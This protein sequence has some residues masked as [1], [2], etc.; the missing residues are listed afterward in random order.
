M[1]ELFRRLD[2]FLHRRR[3]ERDLE[4]E[5][6][7][8]LALKSEALGVAD[9]RREFGNVTLLQEDCRTMWIGNF[10][11]QLAQDARYA[12]RMI[13][14]NR[15]FAAM[16][17]ISLA[18]GIGANTAIYSFVEAILLRSVPLVSHPEQLVVLNWHAQGRV[19]VA[20]SVAGTMYRENKAG[21]TSPN[22]PFG[23]Y[24]ALRTNPGPLSAVFGYTPAYGS[25][26]LVIHGQ[27]DTVPADY[28]SGNYY[29][30]LGVA[31]AAGRFIS[32]DDDR[33][34]APPVAVI[35]YKCWERRFGLDPSA[36]GR[37]IVINNIS[38][39][40]LGVT[41][42]GFFGVN[43]AAEPGVSLPLHTAP[44]FAQKPDVDERRR[45]LDRNFYWL[46]IFGRL[47]P[48]VTFEQAQS[49][50][51][52][53]FRQFA[54]STASS[55]A[56]R[57]NLP[58]LWL[59]EGRAGRDEL[60]RQYSTAIFVLMA[61]VGL[62]LAIACANI[63]N[64]LLA[65][66]ASRRREIAVRVSL[67]A[68]RWSVVR[69]LLT[70]SVLLSLLGG[71]LGLLV[72]FGG[73][74]FISWLLDTGR[75][76][77]T[78]HAGIN[79]PVLGFTLAL[80]LGTGVLFG[81]A[82]AW[83]ATRG[84]LTPALK[85]ARGSAPNRH[86]AAPFSLGQA[87]VVGQV[88][89]SLMLV[90]AAGLFVHTLVNLNSVHLGFQRENILL[91]KLNA[92][93][94]GYKDEALARFYAALD[95]SFQAIPGVRSAAFSNYPLGAQNWHEE[96]V[97]IP[98][99]EPPPGKPFE[100][101]TLQVAPSFLTTMSIPV[102]SGRGIEDRDVD[103]PRVAVVNEQF[104]KE[105][106]GGANPVGRF[107]AIGDS[108]APRPA[109]IEIV[110][111]SR[112][113]IYN[114]VKEEKPPALAYIPYTQEV[115][116]LGGVC[117]ELRTAGDPLELVGAVRHVVH[118]A[119]PMI[120]VSDVNTQAQQIDQTIS[121]ERTLANLGACLGI[122]ALVIAC[123][124]LYGTIAYAVARRTGEIGIRMALGARS[125]SIVWMVLRQV[126]ALVATGLAIG[127]VGAWET[128]RFVKSFL[129]GA[130]PNDPL[131]LSLAVGILAA[132]A[133]VAAYA[134]ARRAGRT[135]PMAALRCE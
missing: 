94:A 28:V 16:A 40:V 13:S 88:A 132:A 53:Q 91:F 36:I 121:Q 124:G 45:F 19:P 12:L 131:S 92:R 26:N 99:V 86:S 122:L 52:S 118:D 8:H 55:P 41:P 110:G 46:E 104:A 18:L 67:G 101:A 81:L 61:M 102:L 123:V 112:N 96:G 42:Q 125:G 60:R 30:S 35:S 64:L 103:S 85:T 1:G 71:A 50:L 37:S 109:D 68:G 20:R 43:P 129:F 4:D 34:G 25:L 57:A 38:F 10:A 76:D 63:A 130:T 27:A 95:R 82:P 111:V 2:F 116:D 21:R 32:D 128:T 56:E 115:A 22:F 58:S 24:E 59:E 100:L 70:E 75:P 80:A 90:I 5:M 107:I 84:D 14:A 23:A 126:V 78:L 11:E 7:H 74:R 66:A 79:L 87:L 29:A 117:F 48:D 119:G 120:P 65:R 114:S 9:A 73:I 113:A 6:R 93:P 97:V 54:E 15:L 135:D 33:A 44:L 47:R 31:P 105:F 106:L 89:L 77:F 69:Q 98:G 72:A 17:V 127:F 62:I 51:A 39:T 133:L 108:K 49:R 83:Q 3:F 134:P